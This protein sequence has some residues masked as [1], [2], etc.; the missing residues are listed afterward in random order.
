MGS[1]CSSL[2]GIDVVQPKSGN[3]AHKL[4]SK[5]NARTH[6]P[7]LLLAFFRP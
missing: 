2:V 7:N 4:A 5:V 3:E 6:G 1:V